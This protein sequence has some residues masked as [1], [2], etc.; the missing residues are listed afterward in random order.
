MGISRGSIKYL[1]GAFKDVKPIG[2]TVLCLAVSGVDANYEELVKEFEF[3]NYDYRRLPEDE[4]AY[5]GITQFGHTIHQDVFFKMIGFDNVES[6]DYYENEKP[7]YLVDLNKPVG[8][9]FYNKYDAIIDF[10]TTEH[11]FNVPQVLTN[12]VKMLKVGGHVIHQVPMNNYINHGY[13][14]LSPIIFFDF[15][16]ENGFSGFSQILQVFVYDK[17]RPSEEYL[18]VYFPIGKVFNLFK[19]SGINFHAKKIKQVDKIRFPIQGVYKQNFGKEELDA[20]LYKF[21]YFEEKP[22]L[23][24]IV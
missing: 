19:H 21:P 2:G 18:G 5:D 13:Y 1:I 9:E 8:K 15:Y 10:G 12:I 20:D 24:K 16:N 11:C 7:T 17:G 23:I 4:I 22:R 3:Q 14:Q 6:M